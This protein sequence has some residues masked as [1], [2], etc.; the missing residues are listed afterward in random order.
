MAFTKSSTVSETQ[1]YWFDDTGHGGVRVPKGWRLLYKDP[2]GNEWKPVEALGE[3]GVSKD[4]YN[5]VR[6]KPVNT[7]A[8]RLELTL[9]PQVSAG[10]Q[11]WKVK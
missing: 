6:F 7:A 3:Y 4:K 8:L 11:E 9:Q 10:V 1:I 2:G 5:V